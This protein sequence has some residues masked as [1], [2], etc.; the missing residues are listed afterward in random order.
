MDS[1]IFILNTKIQ[2]KIELSKFSEIFFKHSFDCFVCQNFP[3][4]PLQIKMA[5]TMIS[6]SPS[7]TGGVLDRL[8]RLL[9]VFFV[10]DVSETM[11]E[12]CRIRN[13]MRINRLH[14]IHQNTFRQASVAK[15]RRCCRRVSSQFFAVIFLI[16]Q[17]CVTQIC[18]I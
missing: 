2:K 3:T 18:I 14:L 4:I 12:I 7:F 6:T 5:P 17:K 1:Q 11:T 10:G 8:R 16:I 13:S 15:C 9:T